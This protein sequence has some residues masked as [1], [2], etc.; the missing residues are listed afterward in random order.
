MTNPASEDGDHVKDKTQWRVGIAALRRLRRM[1][2]DEEKQERFRN[3][4]VRFLSIALALI[5]FLV[6]AALV[7]APGLIQDLFRSLS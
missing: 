7:F 6:L 1:V 5:L 2:D 4:A 3:A